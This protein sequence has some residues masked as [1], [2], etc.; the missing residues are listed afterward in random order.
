M[1]GFYS[2]KQFSIEHDRKEAIRKAILMA[3]KNDMVV[4]AGKGHENYQLIKNTS[5]P[6][7]DKQVVCEI[8]QSMETEK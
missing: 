7:S 5:V 3:S 8:L 4:V 2:K 1:K 6:F